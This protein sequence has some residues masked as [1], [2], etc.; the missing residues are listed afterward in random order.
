MKVVREQ[1]IKKIHKYFIFFTIEKILNKNLAPYELYRK[2]DRFKKTKFSLKKI[3]EILFADLKATLS[4][5]LPDASLKLKKTHL[6]WPVL[7]LEN[8]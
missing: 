8:R 6:F 3:L 4:H 7:K 1:A 2:S 5:K